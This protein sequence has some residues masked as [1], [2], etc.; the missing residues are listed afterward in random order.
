MKKAI[1]FTIEGVQG[2]LTL[3]YGPFKQKLY[4]NGQLIKR[5]K[6]KYFVTTVTGEIEEMKIAYGLD[7]VHVAWF[8]NQKI[9]LQERLTTTEYVLGGIPVL[10]VFFGGIIGAFIGF[11]GALWIYDY[12]RIEKRMQKQVMVAVGVSFLCFLLYLAVAIP[13]NFLMN[14]FK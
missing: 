12:F 5:R 11:M 8:R 6:G 13:F 4:Q 9:P 14:S 10:L 2:E 1:N 7:F 3:E